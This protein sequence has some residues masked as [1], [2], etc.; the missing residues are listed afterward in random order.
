VG[1]PARAGRFDWGRGAG[2]GAVCWVW[3]EFQN[4]RQRTA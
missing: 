2:R 1:E 4:L 3:H